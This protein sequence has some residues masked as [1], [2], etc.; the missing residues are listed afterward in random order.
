M[1][2]SP[3]E[4]EADTYCDGDDTVEGDLKP[5]FIFLVKGDGFRLHGEVSLEE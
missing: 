5:V 4:H 2:A 3:L 1:A